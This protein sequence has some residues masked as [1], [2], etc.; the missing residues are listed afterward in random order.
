MQPR[1]VVGGEASIRTGEQTDENSGKDPKAEAQSNPVDYSTPSAPSS[2]ATE[3][4][5]KG[6]ASLR[7]GS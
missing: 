2:A 6:R 4:V 5:R 3:A 1:R 7:S